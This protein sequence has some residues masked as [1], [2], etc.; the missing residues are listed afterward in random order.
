MPKIGLEL[1]L[2][3]SESNTTLDTFSIS[4]IL[5]S[6]DE[7]KI[8]NYK[9]IL[10]PLNKIN[11][12]VNWNQSFFNLIIFNGKYPLLNGNNTK[13]VSPNF[14][15]INLYDNNKNIIKSLKYMIS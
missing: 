13:Y 12:Q 4:N 3:G 1:Y 11:N 9:I 2:L 7:G 5:E 14:F 6:I 8:D 10:P 15:E